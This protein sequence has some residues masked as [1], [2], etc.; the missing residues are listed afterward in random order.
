[1]RTPTDRPRLVVVSGPPCAGKTAAAIALHQA[2]GGV[3]LDVDEFRLALL[4]ASNQSVEDR[5]LAYRAMHLTARFLIEAGLSP[6]FVTATYTRHEAR[7]HLAEVVSEQAVDVYV[8]Q[9]RVDVLIAVE[10]FRRRPAGH[11]AVD[12]TTDAVVDA[13]ATYPFTH[14]ALMA[15]TDRPIAEVVSDVRALLSAGVPTSLQDWCGAAGRFAEKA[16]RE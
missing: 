1:M 5:N 13:S 14:S 8:V 6:L 10:R 12:L 9:C 2:L 3:R 4:P 7:R 15:N 16:S 11:A